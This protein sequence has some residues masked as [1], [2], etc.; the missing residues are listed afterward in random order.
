MCGRASPGLYFAEGWGPRW[1]PEVTSVLFALVF[2]HL[3]MER[4]G[5]WDLRLFMLFAVLAAASATRRLRDEGS[6]GADA[7]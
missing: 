5:R 1:F 2:S 4:L 6:P 7:C 3:L